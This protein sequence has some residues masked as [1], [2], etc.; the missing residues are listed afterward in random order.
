MLGAPER[1]GFKPAGLM[2]SN[3]EPV[4]LGTWAGEFRDYRVSI[5]RGE[6]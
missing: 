2:A 4:G 6:G 5:S 1:K 3:R